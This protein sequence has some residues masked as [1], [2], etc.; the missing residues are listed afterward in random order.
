LL[1]A[2]DDDIVPATPVRALHRRLVEARVPAVLIEYP[3][4]E[5]GFDLVL[6]QLSPLARAAFSDLERFLAYIR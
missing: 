4:A 3:S 5:H 6:P 2:A 1:L